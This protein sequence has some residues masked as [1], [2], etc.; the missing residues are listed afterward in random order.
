MRGRIL[1]WPPFWRS[2]GHWTTSVT[3]IDF[4]ASIRPQIRILRPK[5]P[6][7]KHLTC[8]SEN[9]LKWPP[10]SR[11]RDLEWHPI[12]DFT[13]N[14]GRSTK[15]KPPCQKSRQSIKKC[16]RYGNYKFRSKSVEIPPPFNFNLTIKM[17]ISCNNRFKANLQKKIEDNLI[18]VSLMSALNR[19]VRWADLNAILQTIQSLTK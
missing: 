17:I 8:V 14:R 9:I 5:K 10:I 4:K 16:G 15:N 13:K 12:F 1:K 18:S 2:G 7:K 19:I 6:R 11:S 3:S